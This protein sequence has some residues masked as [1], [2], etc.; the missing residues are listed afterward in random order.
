MLVGPVP[1]IAE[2]DVGVTGIGGAAIEGV[3]AGG[4]KR[5]MAGSGITCATPKIGKAVSVIRSRKLETIALDNI[6]S[7]SIIFFVA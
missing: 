7:K 5:T 3:L 2:G 1:A 4:G 6:F